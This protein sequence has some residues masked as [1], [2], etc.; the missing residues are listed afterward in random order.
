[1]LEDGTPEECWRAVRLYAELNQGTAP[2]L[3]APSFGNRSGRDLLV[4]MALD[5]HALAGDRT[6][7]LGLLVD[8]NTLWPVA[9]DRA[10]VEPLGGQEQLDLLDRLLPLLKAREPL[11]RS[12]GARAVQRLSLRE[13]GTLP[14]RS[15]P[16]ILPALEAAYRAERPG[17]VRD[18]LAEAV[19]VVGGPRHWQ[20]ATGNPPGLLVCLRDLGQRNGQ[21]FFWLSLRPCGLT[22]HECPTLLLERLNFVGWPVQTREMP[23]PVVNLPRPWDEGWDG[24]SYLLVQFPVADLTPGSWRSQVRGT[25]GKDRVKWTSEP[26]VLAV[27]VPRKN[28]QPPARAY[29]LRS[30]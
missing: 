25:A 28:P 27:E 9:R 20:E 21:G 26:R 14:P 23:L 22:V 17:P 18:D 29:R 10:R 30:W 7:A 8:R 2:P 11:L 6:R 15:P 24:R 1:V 5:A 16:G 13:D 19:C 12:T 4:S 3:P